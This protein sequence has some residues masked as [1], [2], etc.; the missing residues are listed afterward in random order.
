MRTVGISPK[1][2]AAAIA[3]VITLL[4]SKFGLQ[5]NP[6]VE[7]V[8]SAIAVL[9]AAYFAPAGT[10]EDKTGTASDDLLSAEAVKKLGS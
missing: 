1:V 2:I 5:G 6:A 10:V 7:Q 3:S 9:A 4:L 8:A